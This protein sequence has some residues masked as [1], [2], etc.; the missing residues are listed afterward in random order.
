MFRHRGKK[1][2][3]RERRFWRERHLSLEAL[4]ARQ[5]LAADL[6]LL[7]SGLATIL[8]GVQ[9]KISNEVLGNSMPL[10]GTALKT[11]SDAAVVELVKN[12]I[13]PTTSTS[14]GTIQSELSSQLGA[15]LQQFNVTIDTV[16][17]VAVDIT[18][19]KTATFQVGFSSGLPALGLS[20]SG[21]VDVSLGFVFK[22]TIGVDGEGYRVS[23]STSI[24][25]CK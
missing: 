1:P 7:E 23:P 15:V 8:G 4:E 17:K 10:V 18:L 2:H 3:K 12:L 25:R 13:H 19:A 11:A 22:T 21:S 16:D 6:T 5:M 9:Q 24:Y 20:A 14:I